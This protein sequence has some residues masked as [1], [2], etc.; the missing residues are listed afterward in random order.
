MGSPKK[1]IVVDDH[2]LFRE[3]LKTILGHSSG[4]EVI[5]EAGTAQDGLQ[6]VKELK[7]DLVI[8]DISLPDRSGIQLIRD[9]REVFSDVI[10]VVVS[11]HS[12]VDYMAE[13]FQAGAAGYVTK[14][15]ASE[16]LLQGLESV[17]NG[18][19]FLDS[20]VP[21]EKLVKLLKTPISQ[22][23]VLDDRYSRLTQREQEIM[24]MLVE[25]LSNKAIADGL[26]ISR[27]TVENHRAHIFSKLDVHNTVELVRYA[28]KLGLIDLDRWSE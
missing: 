6:Y 21:H 10:V 26:C 27:K 15:S 12:R 14:E 9:I 23:G 2:P 5:A 22:T 28:A 1:I 20:A 24:R 7:P 18:H 4:F 16:K 8:V 3:G 11:M 19:Y 25:G 17:S 13:A